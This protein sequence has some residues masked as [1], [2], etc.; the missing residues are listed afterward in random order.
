MTTEA[1]QREIILSMLRTGT[2][3]S[4]D[5]VRA[6]ILRYSARIHEL[7]GDGYNIISER[8]PGKRTFEFKLSA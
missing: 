8:V 2:K 6:G 5:F 3:G 1:T 7:R 4:M